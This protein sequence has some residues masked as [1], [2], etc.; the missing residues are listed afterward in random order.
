MG[1]PSKPSLLVSGYPV[2]RVGE[3]QLDHPKCEAVATSLI[4]LDNPPRQPPVVRRLAG[5][6]TTYKS[7][8]GR[9]RAVTEQLSYYLCRI[10]SKNATN[11]I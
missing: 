10:Y 7:S 8:R 11:A 2:E 1:W 5:L 3:D 4:I 6:D 9:S